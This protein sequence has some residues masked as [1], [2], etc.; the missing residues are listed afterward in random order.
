MGE[1]F[2]LSILQ[3]KTTSDFEPTLKAELFFPF[4]NFTDVTSSFQ[5]GHIDRVNN[6]MWCFRNMHLFIWLIL[7]A[8]FMSCVMHVRFVCCEGCGRTGSL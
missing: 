1:I 4:Q 7:C 6:C 8:L 5:R 2:D 3:T